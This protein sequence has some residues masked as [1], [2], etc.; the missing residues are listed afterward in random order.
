MDIYDH[1][2]AGRVW[3]YIFCGILDAIWQTTAYWLMGTMSNDPSKL[4]FFTGFYKSIQSAGAAEIWRA[5]AVKIPYMNM[6]IFEWALL[7]GNLVFA[8]PMVILR[9]KNHTDLDDETIARMDGEGHI[10]PTE[11]VAA[12]IK[13]T[14]ASS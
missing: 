8:S 5:D 2:Y 14:Q 11:A 12:E 1:G 10:R 9:I 7:V 3:F 4:V 13:A 6:F